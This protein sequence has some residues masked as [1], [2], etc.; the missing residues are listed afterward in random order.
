MGAMR[1]ILWDVVPFT[2]MVAMEGCTIGLTILA[3][4]AI[5]N[6]MSPLVFVF[7]TNALASILLLPFSFIFHCRDRFFFFFFFITNIMRACF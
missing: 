4:T 1:A 5:T 2:V 6:G 3:K 7:Y